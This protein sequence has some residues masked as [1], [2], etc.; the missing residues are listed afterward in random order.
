M[1]DIVD[2]LFKDYN[3]Y[4]FHTQHTQALGRQGRPIRSLKETAQR[5]NA[6][7][8]MAHWCEERS[9]DPR[10]WLYTLFAAR[11]WLF[12]PR[13]DHLCSPKHIERYRKIYAEYSPGYYA[14]R[15]R[16]GLQDRQCF[17]P[18]KDLSASTESLKRRYV[19]H[20]RDPDRCVQEMHLT[21][22]YHPHSEVCRR[23]P[24]ANACANTLQ[25]R[26][27]SQ[28]LSVREGSMTCE[29]AQLRIRHGR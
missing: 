21:M 28:I 13:F 14:D 7:G 19:E 27:G 5:I 26:A 29:E 24:L 16:E 9:I 8:E 11:R 6:L 4:R 15:Y 23:C 3:R 22:G 12:A 18:N 20:L 10:H 2:Q 17:N 1:T 25:Q